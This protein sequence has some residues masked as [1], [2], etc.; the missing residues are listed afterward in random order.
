MGCCSSTPKVENSITDPLSA[1]TP[2]HHTTFDDFIQQ[3]SPPLVLNYL[4]Q[5]KIASGSL[6][7]VF[8]IENVDSRIQFAAKVYDVQRLMFRPL[9]E[10]ETPFDHLR[11]EIQLLLTLSHPHVLTLISE[12]ESLETF[13]LILVLPFAKMGTLQS[14]I[15][16]NGLTQRSLIIASFMAAEALN[17]LH[18]NQIVH[19]D[20]KPENVLCFETKY[21]VI[22][23]LSSSQKVENEDYRLRDQKGT[24]MFLAPEVTTGQPYL[25]KPADVWAWGVL[26]YCAMFGE[27]PFRLGTVE[28]GSD[29]VRMVAEL[30][31]LEVLEFPMGKVIEEGGIE[32][33]KGVLEKDPE[34]R[35]KFEDVVKNEFFADAKEIDDEMK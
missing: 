5:K 32:I 26:F 11:Q 27:L 29:Q 18:S 4:F 21:F 31:Q 9:F 8:L 34:K 33:L 28:K 35:W 23:G 14:Q 6:C 30:V 20:V 1:S 17:Y 25:P 12:I 3:Q 19:R 7:S 22:S 10:Q 24:P 2:P 16:K 13:S 15:D